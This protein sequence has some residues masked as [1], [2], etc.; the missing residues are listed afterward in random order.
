MSDDPMYRAWRVPLHSMGGKAEAL[1]SWANSIYQDEGMVVVGVVNLDHDG[2]HV[3]ILARKQNT[4]G[5]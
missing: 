5:T 2:D 4:L 1:E 3:L